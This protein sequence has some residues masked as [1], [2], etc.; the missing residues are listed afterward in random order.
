[1][2]KRFD[3]F[4]RRQIALQWDS[5]IQSPYKRRLDFSRFSQAI[6]SEDYKRL[7]ALVLYRPVQEL[8]DL[9]A[10]RQLTY[11]E[12]LLFFLK[13]IETFN[14]PGL[15]AVIEINPES[16]EKA[17]WCDA[18][19]PPR[20]GM[21]FGMPLLVKDNIA[22]GGPLHTASGSAVLKDMIPL[23]RAPLIKAYED[24]GGIVLGKTNLS[25][26]SFYMAEGGACGY[27]ALG[28]QGHNPH[29]RFGVG[30]SS[31]GS[32]VGVY[33]GF[34]PFALGTE[35]DGSITYP[36]SQN[37]VV[38]LYPTR[39][40][41]DSGGIV[42]V[43]STL[44][45]PGP[46]AGNVM[47][48]AALLVALAREE[49]VKSIDLKGIPGA[50]V[51][52]MTLGI[53]DNDAIKAGRRTGDDE[54]LDSLEESLAANGLAVK[55]IQLPEN[56]FLLSSETI[57]RQEFRGALSAYLA[58]YGDGS[59]TSLED[60]VA[61]YEGGPKDM[62]PY[63]FKR[64]QEAL[65]TPVSKEDLKGMTALAR[66][67]LDSGLKE[68]DLLVSLSSQLSTVFGIAGY[69]SISVPGMKRPSGEPVGVTLTAGAYEEEKLLKM[70]WA[71]TRFL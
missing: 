15:R 55:R 43:S 38:G 52:S 10:G 13:R 17:R 35:T 57:I 5:E 18:N 37:G 14:E 71:M 67:G 2:T 16:L 62:A 48:A 34:A 40:V 50:K 24:Q 68:V 46:M 58:E 56:V 27:S 11:E 28:G 31:S 30:G 36:S 21:V 41:L 70:A 7:E 42:P 22:T 19:R 47:D 65:E 44:D 39:G 69:P 45:N 3:G 54:I 60:I 4:I 1:M 25:E 6:T 64:L 8:Q 66:E 32:A 53:V 12:I 63:G 26:W 59:F 51:T 61:A 29:G 20:P 33:K 9:V 49:P 23:R